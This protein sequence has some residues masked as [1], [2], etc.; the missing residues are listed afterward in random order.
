MVAQGGIL[1]IGISFNQTPM[2]DPRYICL[3]ESQNQGFSVILSKLTLPFGKECWPVA[4]EMVS[5]I[6]SGFIL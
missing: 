1:D 3:Y 4:M 6:P 5:D 2:C